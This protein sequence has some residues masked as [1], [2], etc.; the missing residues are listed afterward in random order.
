MRLINY[1]LSAMVSAAIIIVCGWSGTAVGQTSDRAARTLAGRMATAFALGRLSRLDKEHLL[2]KRLEL[3]IQHWITDGDDP[4]FEAK[5][6]R[7]FAAMER[8]LKADE[9]EPGFPVRTSGERIS[10]SRGLCRLDLR[11]NQM[12][13]NHVF[14]IRIWY[15][16]AKGKIVVKKLRLLYG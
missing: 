3:S 7:S 8:W 15:G 2:G 16:S 4:E 14:L 9:S 5:T 11:D 10:C 13:H 1:K 12:A 6:F